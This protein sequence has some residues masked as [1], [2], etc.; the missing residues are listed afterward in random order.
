MARAR[1]LL[2]H[3]R[4]ETSTI[5][6]LNFHRRVI[7]ALEHVEPQMDSEPNVEVGS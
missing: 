4:K 7:F 6:Q 5:E 3:N 1:S 2:V